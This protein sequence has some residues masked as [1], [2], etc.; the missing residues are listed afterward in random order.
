MGV[1]VIEGQDQRGRRLPEKP[2]P[3]MLLAGARSIG[4][5]MRQENHNERARECWKAMCDSYLQDTTQPIPKAT[6]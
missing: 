4:N 6:K 5:S 3:E 1:C 2:T